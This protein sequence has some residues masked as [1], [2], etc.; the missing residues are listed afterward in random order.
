MKKYF[1]LSF[2]IASITFNLSSPA[3]AALSCAD[4]GTCVVGDIGPGGG[5]VFFVKSTGAFNVSYVLPGSYGM[6]D[7]TF[8]S[9]L[10]SDQQAALTFDYLEVAPT[11]RDLGMWGAGGATTGGTSLLIGS[12]KLNTEHILITQDGVVANNAALYAD[13]YSNNGFF[14]WYLPSYDEL[15]LM[16]LR[17]KLGPFPVDTFPLGLWSS[18]DYGD[19]SNAGYSALGQLQGNVNRVGGSAGVR[20]IRSFSIAPVVSPVDETDSK[21][22]REELVRKN[23]DSL[24][25]TFNNLESPSLKLFQDSD[26]AGVTSSNV[27]EISKALTTQE[28]TA[29]ITMSL[30]L[31]TVYKFVTIEKLSDNAHNKSVYTQQLVDIGLIEDSQSQKGWITNQ[32][33]KLVTTKM[34]TFTKASDQVAILEKQVQARK[35]RTQSILTKIATRHSTN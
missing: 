16:M 15:L 17:V 26:I 1:L 12:A 5:L 11:G 21:A 20:A 31:K 25:S 33:R 2:L 30:L 13:Q 6:P 24:V 34:D 7:R 8:T 27:E 18:S 22:K 19:S 35:A 23:Q 32:L 3:Q 9:S 14:D 29:P 10:T 28:T 4:G